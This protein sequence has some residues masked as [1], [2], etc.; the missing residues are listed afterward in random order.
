VPNWGRTDLHYRRTRSDTLVP[1]VASFRNEGGSKTSGVEDR[2]QI[3][4]F[5][6]HV[7]IRGGVGEMSESLN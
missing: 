3:S 5:L 4:H 2:G 6:A 1:H 7:K